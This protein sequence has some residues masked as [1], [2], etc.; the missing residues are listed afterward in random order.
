[1]ST[2]PNVL[3][4]VSG[5]PWERG[6][7]ISH[8]NGPQ[9]VLGW[10]GQYG[11]SEAQMREFEKRRRKVSPEAQGGVWNVLARGLGSVSGSKVP[12]VFKRIGGP[13]TGSLIQAL[14][15]GAL[16]YG[17][18]KH[19]LPLYNK[20]IDSGRAAKTLGLLAATGGPLLNLFPLLYNW[21]NWQMLKEQRP[22]VAKQLGFLRAMNLNPGNFPVEG[23]PGALPVT[24]PPGHRNPPLKPESLPPIE[25]ENQLMTLS[26][27]E[28]EE[29]ELR[30]PVFHP[31]KDDVGVLSPPGDR[32]NPNSPEWNQ[33]HTIPVGH[34]S[35]MISRSGLE[36]GYRRP[37][38]RA[39]NEAAGSDRGLISPQELFNKGMALGVGY[40]VGRPAMSLVSRTVGAFA[41]LPR[42]TQEKL[43]HWGT[44]GIML[45]NAFGGKF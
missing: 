36:S 33:R 34:M 15:L 28:D 17:T 10:P 19:L 3:T 30:M 25:K 20:N 38:L 40:L 8:Q 21:R 23:G 16:G 43:T 35:D 11:F 27:P 32:W 29:S 41:G 26:D 45:T 1:M 12:A 7:T 14:L 13:A 37:L 18:G 6:T 22:E 24:H 31:G 44:L 4:Y 39:M 2:S 42:S 5:L 9:S